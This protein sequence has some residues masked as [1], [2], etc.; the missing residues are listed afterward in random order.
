[1]QNIYRDRKATVPHARL[2]PDQLPIFTPHHPHWSPTLPVCFVHIWTVSL[3]S[4]VSLL[5]LWLFHWAATWGNC[6]CLELS[7]PSCYCTKTVRVNGFGGVTT[8]CD[9]QILLIIIWAMDGRK[10]ARNI[11]SS[12]LIFLL[13]NPHY[14][15][16][17]LY[18]SH[19]HHAT[20]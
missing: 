10:D 17:V 19:N 4:A 3:R 1:M 16:N 9:W 12:G 2:S 14:F 13:P 5:V 7:F 15:W 11:L 18:K 8:F 6:L 20:T